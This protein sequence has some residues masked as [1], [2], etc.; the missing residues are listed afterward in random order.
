[1]HLLPLINV[2]LY[3]FEKIGLGLYLKMFD[4]LKLYLDPLL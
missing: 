4:P 3:L 1:M 2:E